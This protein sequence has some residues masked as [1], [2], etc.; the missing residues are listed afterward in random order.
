MSAINLNNYEA[1]LLDHFE[2]N[3]S[4]EHLAELKLF[5]LNHPELNIDLEDSDE[6]PLLNIPDRA[7]TGVNS[8][9]KNED[10]FLLNNRFI[11]HVEGLLSEKESDELIKDT[12]N[13]PLLKKELTLYNNTRLVPEEIVFQGKNKLKK[14]SRVIPLFEN[15]EAGMI[16]AAVIIVTGLFFLFNSP[17]LKNSGPAEI[18]HVKPKESPSVKHSNSGSLKSNNEVMIPEEKIVKE[19][20]HIKSA[21][22]T[23]ELL[24][25]NIPDSTGGVN[26]FPKE[27]T[28]NQLATAPDTM[29]SEIPSIKIA[30]AEVKDTTGN[31][32]VTLVTI[33]EE[34]EEEETVEDKKENF[35]RRAVG[36]ARQANKLGVKSIDG[37]IEEDKTF[38][39]SFNSFSVEK[40]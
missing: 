12:E 29:R 22:E 23:R 32:P 8:L 38:R 34:I 35:W 36:I 24:A 30:T 13:N 14:R 39:L 28:I 18:S 9:Y 11:M 10:E 31:N 6:L 17:V 19:V 16:A 4:G 37:E 40:K 5:A 26:H 25:K 21:P 2:G 15:F 7:F 33:G 20:K 27:E 3:L 1:F